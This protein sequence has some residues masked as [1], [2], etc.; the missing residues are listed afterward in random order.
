MHE[1]RIKKKRPRNQEHVLGNGI[2]FVTRQELPTHFCQIYQI[3]NELKYSAH[4]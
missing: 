1:N 2:D 3:T 4:L